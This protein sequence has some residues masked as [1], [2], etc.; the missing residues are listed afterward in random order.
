M[1]ETNQRFTRGKG[2]LE[3]WLA[4][5]R[6]QRANNLI[7]AEL[8]AGRILDI[9]C[10][11]YPY[12]LSHTVFQQKFAVDQLPP[13]EQGKRLNIQWHTLDLNSAPKLPFEADFFSVVTLLAVVEHLNPNS[14]AALFQETYR[15]LQPGGVVIMTTPAAWSD[16]LLKLMARV[17]LVSAEEIHEH[18][19]AYTLPLLG[20]Y[21][22][23]AGFE[24]TK[25]D[26]G[27]FEL[28]LNM[29]AVAKK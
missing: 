9:G 10:G 25:V 11:S 1:S 17:R 5:L 4:R 2:L 3:P 28:M 18:V 19:F 14:M 22:G 29:W 6:A 7:P 20:W 16:G 24:M 23:K 8:R 21:F 12:F 27:Y 13:S 15:V 26:F